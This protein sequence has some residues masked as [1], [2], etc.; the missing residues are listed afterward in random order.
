MP[1][2]RPLFREEHEIFRN[3]VRRFYEKEVIPYH[4]QWEEEGQVSRD[5]WRKAGD[6]GL[7][8]MSL[9]EEYG[10]AEG[11]FLFS[12]VMMEEQSRA[13][14][15][16][17][18]FGLHN[19]IVAPYI[20]KYG[21][22]EQHGRW[23]PKMAR[24]ELIGAIAMTEPGT[25]S[26]LQAVRTTARRDGDHYIV[27]GQKTFI[28]NGYMSDLVIVVCKTDPEAGAKGISLIVVESGMEGF[29]KG[30]KLKK[31]GMKAQDTAELFFNNVRVP[32]ENLLGQEGQGFAYLM[33]ELVQERLVI[34][35]NSIC[36]AER[37]LEK[38]IE[39]TKERQ[40]FGQPIAK[41]QNTR[42]KLAELKTNVTIGRIFIDHC[43]EQHLQGKLDVTTAAMAKYW[44][45]EMQCALTD[46]CVQ[47]HGGYGYMLE[48]PVA[49]AFVDGR[50][51]RIYGGS[52]EIMKEL[53]SRAIV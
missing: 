28:T 19:D 50:V 46:D 11:D 42:F 27:N 23:L 48:F 32:K 17:P 39:Y 6:A 8:C 30:R 1:V 22:R 15:S 10:G 36:A 51:Q 34:G 29:E 33:N 38:T 26:D 13:G 3:T 20:Y 53:I 2:Q 31:V 49:K 24:G 18:G 9:P 12:I 43:I 5:L 47:L 44:C 45:S 40:A 4:E 21:N 41:F 52:N 35:I 37:T 25:G 14:T 7:L 16:G